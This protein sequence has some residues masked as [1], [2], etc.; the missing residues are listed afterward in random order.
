MRTV[1]RAVLLTGFCLLA[2]TSVIQPSCLAAEPSPSVAEIQRAW[3]ERRQTVQP[4][5]YKFALVTSE[6]VPRKLAVD[7]NPFDDQADPLRG[8]VSEQAVELAQEM[9][10]KAAGDKWEIVVSGDSLAPHDLTRFPRAR[11]AYVSDGAVNRTWWESPTRKQNLG[12]IAKRGVPGHGRRL[13]G[14]F[15]TEP[16]WYWYDPAGCLEAHAVDLSSMKI[17]PSDASA[18]ENSSLEL[19]FLQ[20]HPMHRR[21]LWTIALVENQRPFLIRQLKF[22]DE[23][24]LLSETK[25]EYVNHHS[26]DRVISKWQYVRFNERSL[27]TGGS[28]GTMTDFVYNPSF[29]NDDYKLDFPPGAKVRQFVNIR[30]NRKK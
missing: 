24:T 23:E 25:L 18:S 14:D 26:G 22:F 16:T 9:T 3:R 21:R 12:T 27:E 1:H 30:P 15:R 28:I 19:H 5:Q 29:H 8:R 20:P 4:F 6:F 10:F 7:D 17:A 2:I 13:D 11:H